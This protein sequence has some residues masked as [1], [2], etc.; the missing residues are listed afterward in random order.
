MQNQQTVASGLSPAPRQPLTASPAQ[1]PLLTLS[2]CGAQGELEV[3]KMLVVCYEAMHQYGK[4]PEA[5]KATTQVFCSVLS[6]FPMQKIREAF[7]EY[8]ERFACL[9]SPACIRKLIIPQKYTDA[10]REHHIAWK[11]KNGIELYSIELDY[12][13]QFGMI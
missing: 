11:R 10:E 8:V 1:P 4:Q 6:P 12:L 9:P 3:L 7:A 5:I 2:T 13:R